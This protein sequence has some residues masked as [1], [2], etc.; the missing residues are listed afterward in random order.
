MSDW[1]PIGDNEKL[2]EVCLECGSTAG[3]SRDAEQRVYCNEHRSLHDVP[4]GR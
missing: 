4:P 3:R 1:W 2:D